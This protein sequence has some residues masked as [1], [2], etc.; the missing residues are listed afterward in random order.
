[1][2]IGV[3]CGIFFFKGDRAMRIVN[4]EM[5]WIHLL[6][7]LLITPV[8]GGCY[9]SRSIP[10]WDQK[11][12]AEDR[13][14]LVLDDEAVLDRETGLVW[15]RVPDTEHLVEWEVAV[16]GGC[17]NKKV[18]GRKGWRFPAL[19]EVQTLVDPSQSAPSL[20]TG[21]PFILNSSVIN[22]SIVF[23]TATEQR[24]NGSMA[25][26]ITFSYGSNFLLDKPVEA[27][28]WCVRGGYMGQI[29]HGARNP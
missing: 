1:M 17:Y 13:F 11:L 19:Y 25:E 20:P 5:S 12:K 26:A 6:T 22:G 7:F 28:F 14:V 3:F 2:F 4:E 23:W 24:Q 18:G 29:L 8:M 10:S 15:E 16:G 21:H 9:Q 27:A